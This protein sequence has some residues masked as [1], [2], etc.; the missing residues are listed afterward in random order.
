MPFTLPHCTIYNH[1]NLFF[2]QRTYQ[3]DEF[4]TSSEDSL[5]GRHRNRVA[6]SATS[7]GGSTDSTIANI[8]KH[9]NYNRCS[10]SR[11]SA[12]TQKELNILITTPE[13]PELSTGNDT[14][15]HKVTVQEPSIQ[16]NNHVGGI[17]REDTCSRKN[18]ADQSVMSK[19]EI[20]WG[21]QVSSC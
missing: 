6:I 15:K 21:P 12:S 16:E 2:L 10:N 9:H 5:L 18:K 4:F 3:N 19:A 8:H 20:R 7:F 17:I 11:M 1:L 14:S 13:V